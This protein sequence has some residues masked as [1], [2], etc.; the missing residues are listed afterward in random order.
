MITKEYGKFF[1]VC[2]ICDDA[3]P[4]FDTWG[5]VRSH[6]AGEGWQTRK[7]KETDEWENYCPVCARKLRRQ[8]TLHDFDNI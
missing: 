1:C 8:Q 2:D 6:I 4:L 7:N 3:T 5:E